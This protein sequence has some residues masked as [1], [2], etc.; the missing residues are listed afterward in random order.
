MACNSFKTTNKKAYRF[1]DLQSLV[2]LI[3]VKTSCTLFIKNAAVMHFQVIIVLM[4]D[5]F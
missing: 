4:H 3:L 5:N 1:L 2:S